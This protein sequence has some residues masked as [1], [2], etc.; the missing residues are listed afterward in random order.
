[1]DP[2]LGNLS[3]VN[4]SV[5]VW[6]QGVKIPETDYCVF[7]MAWYLSIGVMLQSEDSKFSGLLHHVDW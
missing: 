1:L 6:S 3:N 7:N 2:N 4:V 5:T